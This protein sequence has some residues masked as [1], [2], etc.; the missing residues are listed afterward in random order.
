MTLSSPV[1]FCAVDKALQ[2]ASNQ[3]CVAWH[4]CMGV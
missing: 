4:I 2:L 3:A 1:F